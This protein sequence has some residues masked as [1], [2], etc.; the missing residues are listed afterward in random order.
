M[1]LRQFFLRDQRMG[2][3]VSQIAWRRADQLG[4][5]VRML[6]LRAIHLDRGSPNRISAAASTMRVLPDPV[7]PRNNKFPTGRPF[8]PIP[9]QK[10][11][12]RSATARMP[13]ACPTI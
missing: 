1:I 2:F 4:D 5:L 10:T 7:G 8:E 13:S 9:A 11:W 12:Y 6:K 3:P